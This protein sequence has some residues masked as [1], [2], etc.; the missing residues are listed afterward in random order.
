MSDEDPSRR[1]LNESVNKSDKK[2]IPQDI[3]AERGGKK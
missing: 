1:D 3:K 2:Q